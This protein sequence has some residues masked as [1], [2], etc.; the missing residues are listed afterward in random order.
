MLGMPNGGSKQLEAIGNVLGDD[1]VRLE[2]LLVIKE[3]VDAEFAGSL[4]H[5]VGREGSRL[6]CLHIYR[7]TWS[8]DAMQALG[9]AMVISDHMQ[10]LASLGVYHTE[11]PL[12]FCRD[13]CTV[14]Q[15][16][17][18]SLRALHM[19]DCI[20]MDARP[21]KAGDP[22]WD[23]DMMCRRTEWL[24]RGIQSNRSIQYF[25]I[26]LTSVDAAGLEAWRDAL[27]GNTTLRE[28]YIEL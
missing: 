19:S 25:W 22:M 12:Q 11:L 27:R 5:L 13:L 21:I 16:P 3:Q 23:R 18:C 4:C 6:R 14:M 1:G 20:D 26:G 9:P 17:H 15:D 28:L 24:A 8:D 10:R 7:G 2:A